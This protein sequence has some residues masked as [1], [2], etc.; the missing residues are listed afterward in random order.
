MDDVL[1]RKV[2]MND[3]ME[4][5]SLSSQNSNTGMVRDIIKKNKKSKESHTKGLINYLKIYN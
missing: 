1:R 4:M 5:T 2:R 3:S